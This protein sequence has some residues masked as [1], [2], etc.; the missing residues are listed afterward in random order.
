MIPCGY[1]RKH[2]GHGDPRTPVDFQ[3]RVSLLFAAGI[4]NVGGEKMQGMKAWDAWRANKNTPSMWGASVVRKILG[5]E[6]DVLFLPAPVSFNRRPQI[7]ARN[8]VSEPEVV[9]IFW[10]QLKRWISAQGAH[11]EPPLLWFW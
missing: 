6:R 9:P 7:K 4:V 2:A 5:D 10:L 11:T 1:N 3:P 8:A